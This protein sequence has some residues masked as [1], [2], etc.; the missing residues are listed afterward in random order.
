MPILKDLIRLPFSKTS[1][2]KAGMLTTMR[3]S[4]GTAFGPLSIVGSASFAALASNSSPPLFQCSRAS[5]KS[6]SDFSFP[7]A[8][9][10]ASI[11]LCRAASALPG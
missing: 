4:F 11:A 7:T 8:L 6:C 1:M 9:C 3:V 5:T 2:R 10:I